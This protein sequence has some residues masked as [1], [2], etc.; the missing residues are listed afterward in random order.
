MS[1]LEKAI[2]LA[3]RAHR[4]QVDRCGQP[5]ILHPLHLMLQMDT[6]AERMAAVL[7][8]VVE[9]TDVTL[10]D[11]E[12]EGFPQEVLQAVR[13]L[14]HDRP[15]NPYEAYVRALKENP[16]ARKVKLADLQHNMD[17]RR[18]DRVEQKD[19]ERLQR[20]RQAWETLSE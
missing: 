2:S 8:D 16:I 4:G 6:D 20:Y 15:D 10:A 9:D 14:T 1:L 5:Y 12:E 19:M 13:L 11:L 7:H 18:L 3:L 17:L